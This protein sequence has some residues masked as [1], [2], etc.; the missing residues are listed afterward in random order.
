MRV[1][2]PS[3]FVGPAFDVRGLLVWGFTAGIINTLLDLAGWTIPWDEGRVIDLPSL[4]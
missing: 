1:R 2:H 3:G 4:S